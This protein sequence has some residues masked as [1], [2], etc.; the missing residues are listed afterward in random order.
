MAIKCLNQTTQDLCYLETL[1]LQV[2][3]APLRDI[4]EELNCTCPKVIE[5]L[6]IYCTPR[7]YLVLVASTVMTKPKST[8]AT[9]RNQVDFYSLPS[10]A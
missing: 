6:N 9:L 1:R 3:L 5:S 10:Q 2:G 7:P 4:V 8:I